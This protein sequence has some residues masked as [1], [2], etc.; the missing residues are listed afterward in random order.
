MFSVR[1]DEPFVIFQEL[2]EIAKKERENDIIDLS[3]GDPG[4]GFTPSV[5]GREFASFVIFLDSIL[6][7]SAEQRFEKWNGKE[8]A[9]WKDIAEVTAKHFQDA[10]ASHLLSLL[11]ECIEA[12][13]NAAKGEGKTWT[14]FSVL[15]SLFERSTMTG[16]SYLNPRGE[17]WSRVVVA[18]WHR[19]ELGIKVTSDDL[20]LVNG[21][22]H[23]IGSLF[24]ALGTEGC[25]FLKEGDAVCIA[26]PVY[27][28]YNRI[29]EERGLS[30][31]TL[32]ID[33][34][35]GK[36]SES[37]LELLR[38]STAH[39]K[40]LFL[41]DPH[42]PTGFSLSEAEITSL[43]AIAR[44][45]N[46]LVITDEVYSSFFPR[47]KTMLPLCPERTICIN[48]RSKIER[49]TGLR[50]G[51]IIVLPEGQR[52]IAKLLHLKDAEDFWKLLIAAKA[53]GRAG[54]QFQHTTFVPGPSQLLGIAHIVLGAEER[55]TYFQSLEKN[56]EIFTKALGLPHQG[57][58]YYIIFDL[59]TL[60]GVKTSSLPIEERLLRLAK[61]GVIYIPAYRFFANSDRTK[62]GTLTSVR[63]SFAN[64]TAEHL[65]S[66]SAEKLR[67][68]S[69][70]I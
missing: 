50:F 49:S 54:G 45:R 37:D 9:L 63:A 35:T 10:T 23:A 68:R 62:P 52:E 8:D 56:R 2:Q 65:R 70:S 69:K 20:L 55:K 31:L 11:W 47:K 25:G 29:L 16:G 60:P 14:D 1:D 18:A 32:A 19:A 51:E 26:S 39:L 34:I 7:A 41:I 59:D 15:Q 67:T 13:K 66:F 21:A 38:K 3:R 27:A 61:A 46:L 28:P 12:A 17:E 30:V 44:E 64:A 48:G 33:P 5:R 4:Y 58:A 24:K 6:N 36:L 22:S 40:A 42:N 43:A 57:N 53:P